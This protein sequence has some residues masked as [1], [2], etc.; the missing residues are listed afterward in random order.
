MWFLIEENGSYHEIFSEWKN[1]VPTQVI[2]FSNPKNTYH[3]IA[4]ANFNRDSP[5]IHFKSE[6]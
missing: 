2:A 1:I 4:P 5:K 6:A 3:C